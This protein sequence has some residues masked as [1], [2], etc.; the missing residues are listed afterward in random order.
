MP[1][2]KRCYTQEP[3]YLVVCDN[4]GQVRLA[5]Y[6]RL[7][8]TTR[9]KQLLLSQRPPSYELGEVSDFHAFSQCNLSYS[10]MIH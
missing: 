6:R 3:K 7:D 2:H 4:S 9:D 5:C 1:E 10:C 8:R